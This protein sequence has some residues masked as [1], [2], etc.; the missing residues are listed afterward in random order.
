MVKEWFLKVNTNYIFSRT[1]YSIRKQKI[2][3]YG[4]EC[5]YTVITKTTVVMLLSTI[6]GTLKETI[7]LLIFYTF[8]RMFGFGIHA[9]KNIYCW[10]ISLIT[11][12]VLP[13]FIKA[14]LIRHVMV[15][16][17]EL[18]SIIGLAIWAPADTIKRPLINKKKRLIDKGLLLFIASIYII[19][20]IFFSDVISRCM[21]ISMGLEFICTC[22][23][24]Y[25]I[26]KMTYNNYKNF[27][28]V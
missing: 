14:I 23:L 21:M 20:S 25:I 12:I 2:I 4:L 27:R 11:Y 9:T 13:L 17:V 10:I 1:N 22:P 15:V 5:I 8:M 24:T 6:F 19:Y 18:V 16:G 7:L 26:F 28:V 3:K